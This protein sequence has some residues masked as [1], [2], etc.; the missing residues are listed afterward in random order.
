M[1]IF[2]RFPFAS[3]LK[4]HKLQN[5]RFSAADWTLI[6]GSGKSGTGLRYVDFERFITFF[7]RIIIFAFLQKKILPKTSYGV[8]ADGWGK[9]FSNNIDSSVDW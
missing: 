8:A 4:V 7:P 2:A 5:M 3:P 6:N 9:K 1:A